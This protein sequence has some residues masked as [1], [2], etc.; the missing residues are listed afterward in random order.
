MNLSFE[1]EEREEVVSFGFPLIQR[2]TTQIVNRGRNLDL[3]PYHIIQPIYLP[4]ST[5]GK[6]GKGVLVQGMELC[7][8]PRCRMSE[9]E[10][11][12]INQ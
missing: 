2:L 5:R 4:W 3:L 7:V 9:G 1:K 11:E 8:R 10:G 12:R 6:S